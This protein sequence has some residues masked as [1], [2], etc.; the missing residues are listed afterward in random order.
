MQKVDRVE[1]GNRKVVYPSLRRIIRSSLERLR[2]ASQRKKLGD[3]SLF[4]LVTSTIVAGLT[5][6]AT[7]APYPAFT[8]ALSPDWKSDM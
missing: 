5:N 2:S 3:R 4:S 6:G 8:N 1:S 7:L